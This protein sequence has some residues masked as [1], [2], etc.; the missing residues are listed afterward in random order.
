MIEFF[1]PG[2]PQG[3]ARARTF[4]TRTGRVRSCTP[5]KTAAYEQRIRSHCRVA[6]A[7]MREPFFGQGTPIRIILTAYYRP[8]V[9]TSKI[10][11]FRMQHGLVLPT[12]KPDLDNVLKAVADAVN[13]VA[14]KDD[15]QIVE[16]VAKKLFSSEEGIRVEIGPATEGNIQS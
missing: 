16:I 4:T 10:M 7:G 8:P 11:L 1:V 2:P 12:R 5:A 13:G 9:K 6:A 14:Y 3:K 15:S